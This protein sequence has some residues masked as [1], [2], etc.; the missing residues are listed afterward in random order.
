MQE[1]VY[2]QGQA[3]V[4]KA[5]VT[6]IFDNSDPSC[7]PVG[8]EQHKQITVTR[9]V[10]IGG[11]NKY[12]IN[13]H[14]VQQTQ[15]QNFFH[16]VQ[17]NVNNPH[18]LI[19]QGRITK[20]LNMKPVETL[21]MIEEAAGTRMYETKKQ[22]A[23]KTIEKKDLKVDEITK[24]LENDIGPKMQQLRQEK[25]IYQEWSTANH[26]IEK[27]ER[28][29]VAFEYR[30][31]E[32]KVQNAENY[33][34]E[35]KDEISSF[36]DQQRQLQN[37]VEAIDNE[38]TVLEQRRQSEQDGEFQK[39]KKKEQE[40]SKELVKINTNC[41]NMK[42]NTEKESEVYEGILQQIQQTEHSI[43][44]KESDLQKQQNLSSAKKE[45]VANLQREIEAS[46]IKYHNACAGVVS[47]D[48]SNTGSISTLSI[49][50]QIGIWESKVRESQSKLQ[51]EKMKTKH[52]HKKLNE[53]RETMKQE[54]RSHER[55]LQKLNALR[56]EVAEIE[57]K[58]RKVNYSPEKEEKLRTQHGVIKSQIQELHDQIETIT[59]QIEA[60]LNFE[61]RDPE[62]GF[63]RSRVKGLVASLVHVKDVIH[64]T[65]L[66]IAA[67]NKL[68]QVVV[69]NEQTGKLLLGKGVLKKRVTI[70]PLNKISNRTI[71]ENKLNMAASIANSKG[72]TAELALQ[73]VGYDD[74]V[75][76]AMQHVFGNAIICSSS[77]IAESITFD[78][79]IRC[80]TITFDGDTFDPSGTITGGSRNQIGAL[81]MKM[82]EMSDLK[83]RYDDLTRQ[84]QQIE[85][86]LERFEQI[87]KQ[88]S[89]LHQNLQLKGHEIKILEE[90]MSA[91][92][93]NHIC[94]EITSIENE[95]KLFEEV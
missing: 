39:L 17:L 26:E 29:S 84:N 21:S 51:Q 68:Y 90:R 94:D 25:D 22:S 35:M 36:N 19:M 60:R 4:T 9:Q 82:N 47:D 15:I 14:T 53:L 91:S 50:E 61:F 74:E 30:E 32:S 16:S 62:R 3:G 69:D 81:L 92:V 48:E 6:I 70:L 43:V 38:L 88:N 44:E 23:L 42:L 52:N 67:G 72:G 40:L 71:D 41:H 24:I 75:A 8:Y 54:E 7:S 31:A 85:G 13:G 73:L 55:E 95:I 2:K 59:A 77:K 12:L 58:L 56:N 65:A 45:E 64:S 11:K 76:R 66:E 37:E 80:R 57:K 1:L 79:A 27:V 89:D 83:S 63:D 78:P 46:Q 20:V 87:S 93:Y 5:S 49:T 10:I 86:E 18:F 34:Q 28:L 33:Q